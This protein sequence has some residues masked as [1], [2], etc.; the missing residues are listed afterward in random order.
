LEQL[1]QARNDAQGWYDAAKR[2]ASPDDLK[3]ARAA[4]AEATMLENRLEQKA[5]A[6]GNNEL[7]P[8]LRES[9]REIAKSYDVEKALN[10]ATGILILK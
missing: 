2:S 5:I 1:K 10:V 7:L 6:S 8:R 3:K 9:R 4:E